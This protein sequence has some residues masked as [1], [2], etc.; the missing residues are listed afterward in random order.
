VVISELSTRFLSPRSNRGHTCQEKPTRQAGKG[1]RA[2][3]PRIRSFSGFLGDEQ[4]Q[5]VTTVGYWRIPDKDE[6][7]GS[8]PGRPTPENPVPAGVFPISPPSETVFWGDRDQTR[9]QTCQEKPTRQVGTGFQANR[10]REPS[11]SG[12]LG[13]EQWQTATTVR[14]WRIPDKD[15]VPGF[16]S[17]QAHPREPRPRRGFHHFDTFRSSVLG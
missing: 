1:F 17:R 8:N 5:T 4:R 7:P 16:K 12:F 14:Y 6:V 13:D 15:E 10:P 2:D 9:G 11:F 3:Q